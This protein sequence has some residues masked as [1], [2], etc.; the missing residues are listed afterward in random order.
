MKLYLKETVYFEVSVPDGFDRAVVTDC[1]RKNI[2]PM[3][4]DIL[5]QIVID[6]EDLD[7]LRKQ[8]GD[9]VGIKIITEREALNSLNQ[10]DPTK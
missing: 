9:P 1:Y 6:P 7:F 3:F 5:K 2:S 10:K 8:F 4:R